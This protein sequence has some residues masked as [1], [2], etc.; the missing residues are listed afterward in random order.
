MKQKLKSEPEPEPEPV[1]S[2]GSDSDKDITRTGGGGM[3]SR[4][5]PSPLPYR[6]SPTSLS[7]H[8][9]LCEVRHDGRQTQNHTALQ[10]PSSHPTSLKPCLVT[11]PLSFNNRQELLI[12]FQ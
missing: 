6:P 8:H 2:D 4:S 10:T 9:F 5:E 7:P 11:V 1:Q 3:V 12:F